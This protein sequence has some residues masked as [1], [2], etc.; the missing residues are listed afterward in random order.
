MRLT[1]I[2]LALAVILQGCTPASKSAPVQAPEAPAPPSQ[3]AAPT[4]TPAP[5][6]AQAQAPAPAQ[7]PFQPPADGP[8]VV[9]A[10]ATGDLTG[11]GQP[12]T[13]EVLKLKEAYEFQF[14]GVMTLQVREPGDA[15]KA[16]I[17][18]TLPVTGNQV[19]E[20]RLVDFDGNHRPYIVL[21]G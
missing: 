14:D 15:G 21:L 4:P 7:D 17:L 6:Q 9:L 1:L 8:K 5:T 20:L 19:K 10:E 16:R 12:A 2:L 3:Q 11:Q 18:A 13:V